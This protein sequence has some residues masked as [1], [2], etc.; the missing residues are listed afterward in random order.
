MSFLQTQYLH[1][2]III[3]WLWVITILLLRPSF[4]ITLFR[5]GALIKIH[6]KWA[7]NMLLTYIWKEVNGLTLITGWSLPRTIL[8]IWAP[9]PIRAVSATY[10]LESWDI[11]SIYTTG[12]KF[13]SNAEFVTLNQRN[14]GRKSVYMQLEIVNK[15]YW[16]Y[17]SQ[18]WIYQQ[19][20]HFK[21]IYQLCSIRYVTVSNCVCVC[22]YLL[23]FYWAVYST[24][25]T[26]SY[27]GLLHPE[28]K[29]DLF[30]ILWVQQ[31]KWSIMSKWT[32]IFK[33]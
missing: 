20:G 31:T 22:G 6:K 28:I 21:V 16:S 9:N 17:V 18:N 15:S 26:F 8:I 5:Y 25:W 1:K 24:A 4:Q 10:A 30:G 2:R 14:L 27:Y 33:K 19:V 29:M 7:L 11:C 32:N 23:V 13:E 3:F 12:R